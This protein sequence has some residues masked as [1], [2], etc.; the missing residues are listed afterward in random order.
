MERGQERKGWILTKIG[1]R[2]QMIERKEDLEGERVQSG[3][4]GG[5]MDEKTVRA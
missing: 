2:K 5:R 1:L 3:K 4:S